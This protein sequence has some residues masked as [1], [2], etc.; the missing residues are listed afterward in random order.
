MDF[1]IL[2]VQ[3]KDGLITAAKYFCSLADIETEGW[4]FFGRP[5][6]NKPFDQ[7]QESDVIEWV[8]SEAGELIEKNLK[9]QL[10]ATQQPK[11]VAPWLPQT[12]TPS[13]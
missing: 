12:F 4:W 13:I 3:S 5:A 8:K 6:L 7:V 2:E 11:T 10:E 1:K 9:S